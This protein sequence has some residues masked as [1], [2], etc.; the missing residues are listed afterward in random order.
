MRHE[1]ARVIYTLN[2]HE[3]IL[4]YLARGVFTVFKNHAEKTLPSSRCVCV[5]G[6]RRRHWETSARGKLGFSQSL[7]HFFFALAVVLLARLLW[8]FL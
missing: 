6:G 2:L 7:T 3:S 4:F 5:Y 1:F 8:S